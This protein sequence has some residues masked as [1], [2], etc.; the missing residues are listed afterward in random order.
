MAANRAAGLAPEAT[1]LQAVKQ[2]NY[3]VTVS[4]VAIQSGLDLQQVE[5]GL[6][7]L[8]NESGGH[9]QVAPTGDLVYVFSADLEG[10]LYRKSL[11]RQLRSLWLKIW[12]ILFYLVRIS[13]GILL[14]LSIV[15]LLAAI[16]LIVLATLFKDDDNSSSSGDGRG[17]INLNL[18]GWGGDLFWIFQPDFSPKQPKQRAK[19]NFLESVFSFLFGDGNPNAQLDQKRWRVIGKAI[20]QQQGVITAEQVAPYLDDLGSAESDAL[21]DYMLPVLLRFNGS[22]EVSPTAQIVYRFPELQVSASEAKTERLPA[23]LEAKQWN[24]SQ[25][26]P[27]QRIGA[28]ALGGLNFSLALIL[29]GLLLQGAGSLGGLVGWVAA[30]YP[31]LLLYGAGFLTIPLGRWLWLRGYNRKIA[32]LNFDRK[33]RASQLKD[34]SPALREKIEFARGLGQMREMITAEE[35]LYTTQTDLLDQETAQQEQLNQE[36][37]NRLKDRQQLSEDLE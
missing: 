6:L 16:A 25:A 20:Q 15:L 19:L 28:I 34:P 37:Q 7:A 1:L 22:P 12:P 32:D 9:L 17:Q 29:G 10:I 13:F 33:L 26:S 2:L 24:F 21:E 36:W 8:A 11:K 4:D 30:V 5:R 14:I 27:G 35:T 18:G 23:F 3:R 31:L